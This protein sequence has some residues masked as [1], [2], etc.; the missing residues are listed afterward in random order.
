M[1]DHGAG[2]VVWRLRLGAAQVLEF[3]VV[4]GDEDDH[5]AACEAGDVFDHQFGRD[6]VGEVGEDDDH[7]AALQALGQRRQAECV[8]RFFRRVI[9]RRG[10]CLQVFEGAGAGDETGCKVRLRG[11][12]EEADAVAEL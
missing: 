3:L 7:R 10:R 1:R 9:E 12:A 5:V 8:V 4:E 6:R 11:E 2:Y